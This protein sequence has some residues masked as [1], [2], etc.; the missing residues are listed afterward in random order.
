MGF[1]PTIKELQEKLEKAGVDFNPKFKKG[2]LEKLVAGLPKK[3]GEAGAVPVPEL[4]PAPEPETAEELLAEP[5]SV[6]VGDKFDI[7][8]INGRK[9]K[10]FYRS[11][12]TTDVELLIE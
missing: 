1:M 9:H 11:D 10:K 12:G 4:V 6:P 7:I 3:E 5:V 2:K 8:E